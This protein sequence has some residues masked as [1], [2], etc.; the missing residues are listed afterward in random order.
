MTCSDV[1]ERFV[2]V[3]DHKD[4]QGGTR[5]VPADQAPHLASSQEVTTITLDQVLLFTRADTVIIK[6]DVEV[7]PPAVMQ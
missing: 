5:L 2:P 3:T 7:R 1:V 6:M 4:N